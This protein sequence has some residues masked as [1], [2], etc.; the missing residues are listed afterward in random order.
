VTRSDSFTG[1]IGEFVAA[2]TLGLRLVGRSEA[3][4]DAR[5][6]NIG[7][8]VKSVASADSRAPGRRSAPVSRDQPYGRAV[9]TM[10][11]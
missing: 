1:D 8:Q 3:A 2:Q 10:S 6:G 11:W 7:Y 9:T 4:I 5:K